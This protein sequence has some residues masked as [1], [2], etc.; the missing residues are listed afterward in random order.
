MN[1]LRGACL[2]QGMLTAIIL[3]ERFQGLPLIEAHPKVA[4]ELLQDRA[5]GALTEL[6]LD[7]LS[8]HERDAAIAALAARSA[9]LSDG[10]WEDVLA[11]TAADYTPLDPPPQF[12]HPKFGQ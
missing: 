7:D 4:I 2:I 5:D 1:S 3:R 11:L 8:E 12:W 6:T 10:T 9:S